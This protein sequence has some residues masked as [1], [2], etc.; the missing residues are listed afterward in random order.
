MQRILERVFANASAGEETAGAERGRQVG[1]L[2]ELQR[3]AQAEHDENVDRVVL[4]RDQL[5][6]RVGARPRNAKGL[7][8]MARVVYCEDVLERR[9]IFGALVLRPGVGKRPGP[10]GIGQ[11]PGDEQVDGPRELLLARDLLAAAPPSAPSGTTFAS[12]CSGGLA[13]RAPAQER[14][15]VVQVEAGEEQVDELATPP[16]VEGAQVAERARQVSAERGVQRA[17]CRR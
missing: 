2:V 5:A 16:L 10:G 6:Q 1:E 17:P 15:Q 8:E 7:V 3:E 4:A 11:P 12:T 13:A 14:E 9:E